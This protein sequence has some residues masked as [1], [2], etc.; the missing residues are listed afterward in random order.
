M[1]EEAMQLIVVLRWGGTWHPEIEQAAAHVLR[2]LYDARKDALE[3]GC[4]C[5]RRELRSRLLTDDA[6]NGGPGGKCGTS[7]PQ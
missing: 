1:L 6:R 2:R 4:R 3:I 7:P 5:C